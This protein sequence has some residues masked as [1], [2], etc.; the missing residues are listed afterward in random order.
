[1]TIDQLIKKYN[2][3]INSLRTDQ[4][5]DDRMSNDEFY[6]IEAELMTVINDLMRLRDDIVR[7]SPS[8]NI[9]Y[10]GGIYDGETY[11]EPCM[12]Q[13]D[14]GGYVQFS[15]VVSAK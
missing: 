15:E 6:A 14:T 1:M 2:D 7:Y 3:R 9:S 12:K 5:T 4:M 13:S 8:T 10:G 11:H